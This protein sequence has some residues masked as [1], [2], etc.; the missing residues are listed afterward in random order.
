LKSADTGATALARTGADSDT[1]ETLSDQMDAIKTETA[2]ILED[3]GTTIPGTITT[4]DN[5]VAVID[6]IVD[7][8]LADTSTDGVPLTAAAIDA[9]LDE[10]VIGTYTVRQLLKVISSALAGKVSG[11]G[12]STLTFRS[13]DDTVNTI[14]AEVGTSGN[15]TSVTLT[16]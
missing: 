10:V 7:A 14:V 12:T 11:G 5:E 4:I 3:T 13:V 6:G 8:I 2:S 1:L 15:R 9:I 16:V